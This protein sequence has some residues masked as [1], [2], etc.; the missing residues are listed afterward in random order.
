MMIM[1]TRLDHDNDYLNDLDDDDDV[2]KSRMT[3]MEVVGLSFIL[4]VIYL[5]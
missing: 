2:T 5:F 1:R 3:K 4:F